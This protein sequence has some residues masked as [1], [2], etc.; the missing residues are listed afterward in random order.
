MEDG[1]RFFHIMQHVHG[2]KP[3]M[4][5][6][7]AIVDCFGRAGHLREAYTFALSM[8]VEPDA[9]VWRTLLSAC[10]IHDVEDYSGVG[11]KVRERLLELEPR[12]SGNLAMVANTCAEVGL[13]ERVEHI[14]SSMR[15]RGLK[16]MAGMSWVQV[17]GST[18]RFISGDD[19]QGAHR[20][21]YL[22]LDGLNFHMKMVNYQL[23]I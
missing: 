13:W 15:D 4:A 18:H 17:G 20:G 2:I 16:K 19:S 11:E 6:Y 1:R 23:S 3:T 10:K 5:H 22:L 12:R 7:G 21:M 9:V 8:P 14:R